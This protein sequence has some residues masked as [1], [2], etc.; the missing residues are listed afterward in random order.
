MSLKP[1]PNAEVVIYQ[2]KAGSLVLKAKL[3]RESIWLTQ[4][5]IAN[6]FDVQKAAISK[7]IKNI[8]DTNEL[9]RKSTV[10]K[11]ETVRERGKKSSY[12]KS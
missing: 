2:S 3:N 10:S 5:Q 4:D 8:F 9:N 11:M 7:H 6:L 1:P 12:K